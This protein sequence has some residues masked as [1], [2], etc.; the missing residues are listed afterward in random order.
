MIVSSAVAMFAAMRCCDAED[1]G[2][3]E[4][5]VAAALLA[6]LCRCFSR[7]AEPHFVIIA[8]AA[9]VA[10]NSQLVG[11]EA[12]VYGVFLL[13]FI[14]RILVA[15]PPA[16]VLDPRANSDF[17]FA[18]QHYDRM[19]FPSSPSMILVSHSSASTLVRAGA[20]VPSSSSSS[21]PSPPRRIYCVS[22]MVAT[23]CCWLMWLCTWMH[24]WHPI[25]SP[26]HNAASE[27]E[28]SEH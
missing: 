20:I 11:A 27:G 5:R 14:Q 6:G 12:G 2:K 26:T 7:A 28:H 15:P 19:I 10:I 1:V 4:R 13:C 25:I 21:P 23:F 8:A 9:L 24:Q 16:C 3:A 17:F 18:A 22:V